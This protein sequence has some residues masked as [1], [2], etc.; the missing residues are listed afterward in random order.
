MTDKLSM[1]LQSSKLNC[2]DG[3]MM[4]QVVKRQLTSLRTD[5]SFKKFHDEVSKTAESLGMILWSHI[6]IV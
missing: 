4:A 2:S 1:A 5:E 6:T 3:L